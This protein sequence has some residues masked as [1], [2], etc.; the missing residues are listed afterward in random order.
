MVKLLMYY[1]LVIKFPL[2]VDPTELPDGVVAD[3]SFDPKE[4]EQ[5]RKDLI[6]EDYIS[7]WL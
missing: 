2:S 1:L 7:L 3:V 6:D 4:P 5:L